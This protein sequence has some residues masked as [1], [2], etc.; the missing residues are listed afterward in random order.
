MRNIIFGLLLLPILLKSQDLKIGETGLYQ[1]VEVVEIENMDK[2]HIYNKV[3]EWLVIN[4]KSANDVIQ[5]KDKEVGKVIVKGNFST[6]MYMKQ[7]WV[8]HT[9]ILDIKD[10]KYRYT[11]SNLSYYS[12]GS[13]E[14]NFEKSIMSKKK[15][16]S[17]TETDIDNSI[18]SLTKYI[19]STEG[20]DDW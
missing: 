13:G 14:I 17:Q 10:N 20:N 9:L 4:Y 2:G 19:N 6:S 3:L 11:Y 1:K 12:T 7:G 18:E 8:R 5:L 16:I 15:L